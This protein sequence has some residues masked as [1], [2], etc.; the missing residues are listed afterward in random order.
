VLIQYFPEL[1]DEGGKSFQ[2]HIFSYITTSFPGSL[3]FP[4]PGERKGRKEALG[5]R[6]AT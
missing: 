2:Y 5:M 3:F 1:G 4:F 6:L